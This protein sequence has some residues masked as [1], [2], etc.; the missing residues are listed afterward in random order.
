MPIDKCPLIYNLG[1]SNI[2]FESHS[3]VVTVGLLAS[4]KVD[5]TIQPLMD[6]ES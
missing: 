1:D 3:K 6:P 5:L 2:N 4:I